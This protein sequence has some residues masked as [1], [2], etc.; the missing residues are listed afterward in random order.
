MAY[1]LCCILIFCQ[2][3]D[4]NGRPDC[5]LSSL[6]ALSVSIRNTITSWCVGDGRRVSMQRGQEVTASSVWHLTCTKRQNTWRESGCE[7]SLRRIR[8]ATARIQASTLTTRQTVWSH[9]WEISPQT[10]SLINVS[11]TVAALPLTVLCGMQ[12]SAPLPRT[13][14]GT[15][16]LLENLK[17]K[18]KFVLLC[19]F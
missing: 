15:E 3:I 9:C 16:S 8:L 7:G 14:E 4:L 19:K 13:P 6:V 10:D 1:I 2:L 18:C 11:Q 12:E 17:L 5:I